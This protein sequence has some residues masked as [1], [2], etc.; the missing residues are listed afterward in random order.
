MLYKSYIEAHNDRIERVG[1]GTIWWYTQAL[2]YACISI[3]NGRKITLA[4]RSCIGLNIFHILQIIS[5]HTSFT[6]KIEDI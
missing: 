6:W 5:E 1:I 3:L 2:I 4:M